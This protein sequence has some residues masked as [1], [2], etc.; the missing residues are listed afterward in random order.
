MQLQDYIQ[1]MHKYSDWNGRMVIDIKDRQGFEQVE[2]MLGEMPRN[3][4][5]ALEVAT[6]DPAVVLQVAKYNREH[7]EEKIPI[8]LHFI[9]LMRYSSQEH[10][11][12]AVQAIEHNAS[13]IQD[14]LDVAVRD[15]NNDA[16]AALE[17]ADFHGSYDAYEK[18]SANGMDHILALWN[19][20]E[21]LPQNIIEE[22]LDSRGYFSFPYD[23]KYIKYIKDNS[24]HGITLDRISCFAVKNHDDLYD[25][26]RNGLGSV[27][28]DIEAV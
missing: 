17:D 9:P 14:S 16:I 11:L 5:E 28:H 19:P 3:F 6:F 7:P 12:S 24:P 21:E 2:N 4:R 18:N 10:A 27:I 23:A 15:K 25:S 1:V 26:L 13:W 8:T 22:V 20:L